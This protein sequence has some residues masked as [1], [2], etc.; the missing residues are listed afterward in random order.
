MTS[1]SEVNRVRKFIKKIK[2]KV[3][4]KT[5]LKFSSLNLFLKSNSDI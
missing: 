4:W 5:Y 2:N 3:L 1:L